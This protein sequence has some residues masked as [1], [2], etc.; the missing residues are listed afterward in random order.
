MHHNHKP[1]EKENINS[2][3]TKTILLGLLDMVQEQQIRLE[4]PDVA[5]TAAAL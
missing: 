5:W 1:F 4:L 2:D 3:V